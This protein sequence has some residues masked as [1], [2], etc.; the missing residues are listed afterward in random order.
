MDASASI[1]R[2]FARMAM[3]YYVS[4]GKVDYADVRTNALASNVAT[5]YWRAG[6]GPLWLEQG[7]VDEFCSVVR[8]IGPSYGMT[9]DDVEFY[10]D[11]KPLEAGSGPTWQEAEAAF[12][13]ADAAFAKFAA[14]HADDDDDSDE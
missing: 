5:I 14:D 8:R 12:K 6:V 3:C 11:V 9:A 10:C 4:A 13:E 7:F 2:I 1:L